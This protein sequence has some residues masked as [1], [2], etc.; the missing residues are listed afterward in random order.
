MIGGPK[1]PRSSLAPLFQDQR[2]RTRSY[3]K[4]TKHWHNN[5]ILEIS[6]DDLR[7][8]WTEREQVKQLGNRLYGRRN[9]R[10]RK[11]VHH[12]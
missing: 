4:D 2:D 5:G 1:S 3:R 10:R 11:E 8:S 12:G 7:L 9:W 6:L